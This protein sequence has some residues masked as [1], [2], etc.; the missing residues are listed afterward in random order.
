MCFHLFFTVE[1]E[2]WENLCVGHFDSYL[3][4]YDWFAAEIELWINIGAVRPPLLRG[5]ILDNILGQRLFWQ[6]SG[7]KLIDPMKFD[8][9]SWKASYNKAFFI[10]HH[11]DGVTRW[12]LIYC[13]FQWYALECLNC[14]LWGTA[15]PAKG[16]I[17]ELCF[18]QKLLW[19]LILK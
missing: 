1:P 18:N 8:E 9:L 19:N 7:N 5:K 6:C 13:N 17:Y 15:V 16:E 10:L 3:F 4:L 12:D 11:K 14:L 2:T